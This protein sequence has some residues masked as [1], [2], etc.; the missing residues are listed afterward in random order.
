MV[1]QPLGEPG[2]EF[3]VRHI[4]ASTVLYALCNIAVWVYLALTPAGAH[5]LL[6][7]AVAVLGLAASV[8]VDRFR[9]AIARSGRHLQLLYGWSGLT[10]SLVALISYLDGGATSPL[11]LLL[12]IA[13]SYIALAYP[14]RS[15]LAFSGLA[16]MVYLGLAATAP[17]GF[18][19]VVQLSASMLG[20]CGVLGTFAAANQWRQRAALAELA[21]RLELQAATDQLTDCLNRRSFHDRLAGALDRAGAAGD[22]VSLLIVDVDH[23]KTIND[24]YG[25]LAGDEVLAMIGTVLAGTAWTVGA[26]AGRIG[27]DEFAVLLP[28]AAPQAAHDIGRNIQV[29]VADRT[30][31]V[32]VAVRLSIGIG[33]YPADA[34]TVDGLYNEAD[35]SLYSVK[36]AGRDGVAA[37]NPSGPAA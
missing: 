32:P 9:S 21:G 36:W 12:F 13:L 22:P 18:T 37:V 20:L 19:A 27:G 11:C 34:V 6:I 7:F 10:Y 2:A 16:V 14:P 23:F 28:G 25:H 1:H 8:V 30:L 33:S 26:A 31:S 15:V 4:R 29:E 5:R 17:G 24:S 35:R 3:W